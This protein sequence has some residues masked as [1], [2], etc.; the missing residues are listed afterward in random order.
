MSF[1]ISFI[2]DPS[3]TDSLQIVKKVSQGNFKVYKAY[4]ESE[5][6]SYALKMFPKDAIG[7]LQYKNE[8]VLAKLSHP[9]IIQ[10]IPVNVHLEPENDFNCILTEYAK[11]GGIF[12]M[13][14]NGVFNTETLIRTY[15]HQIMDG[16][17]YLHSQGV[18]HL[19]LKPENLMIGSGFTLKIIDFDQAQNIKDKKIN[20]RGTQGYRAPEIIDGS[21]INFKAADIYSLGVLLYALKV[22]KTPFSERTTQDARGEHHISLKGYST[23]T[24]NNAAFWEE[25]I[26]KIND[27]AFFSQDFKDLVNGMLQFDTNKRFTMNDIRKSQWFN[28][29]VLNKEELRAEMKARLQYLKR[30]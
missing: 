4:S 10:Y 22:R 17:S 20:S 15:F 1:T 29:P 9:N 21:C 27:P 19:D 5:R 14:A 28:G 30:K 3:V 25:K 7:T 13:I 8:S 26:A 6:E 2:Q 24:K 12:D 16:L 11:Y 18:A 23:F